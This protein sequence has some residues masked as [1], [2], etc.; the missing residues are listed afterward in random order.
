[1]TN[2]GLELGGGEK[3]ELGRLGLTMPGQS[4]EKCMVNLCFVGQKVKD[5]KGSGYE[6]G[7]EHLD[8]TRF[9]NRSNG[10]TV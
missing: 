3:A 6:R 1:V 4:C 8:L 2:V 9:S 5:E 7:N 10:Q